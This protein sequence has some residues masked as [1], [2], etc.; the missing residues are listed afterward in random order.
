MSSDVFLFL[1]LD[2]NFI[3]SVMVE[4]L[5]EGRNRGSSGNTIKSLSQNYL[6]VNDDTA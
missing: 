1:L 3:F 2:N 5:C 6:S 4:M